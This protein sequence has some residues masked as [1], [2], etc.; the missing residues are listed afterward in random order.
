MTRPVRPVALVLLTACAVYPGLTMVI[1]GGYPFVAGEWFMIMGQTGFWANVLTRLGIPHIAVD[2]LKLL[3][4]LAWLAGVPG[5]WAGDNRA[6]P[7]V[8][9]AAVLTLF[10]GGGPTVMAVLALICL[11]FFRENA[12]EVPA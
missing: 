7:L 6:Y 12:D 1:Q 10:Y 3:V 4:G 5:L 11:L 9:G 8:L 2:V